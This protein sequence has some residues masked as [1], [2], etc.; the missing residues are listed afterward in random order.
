MSDYQVQNVAL[1]EQIQ[2]LVAQLNEESKKN[3]LINSPDSSK[4]DDDDFVKKQMKLEADYKE[5]IQLQQAELESREKQLKGLRLE[6]EETVSLLKQ[7]I[8][9]AEHSLPRAKSH[10][11]EK[12]GESELGVETHE[13]ASLEIPAR[14]LEKEN[15]DLHHALQPSERQNV[16]LQHELSSIQSAS[17]GNLL[18]MIV[19]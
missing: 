4:E 15:E 11:I 17:A 8:E 19:F 9:H 3:A 2:K 12:K 13:T 5:K 6:F 1:K 10:I 14:N 7:K 18:V 16:K